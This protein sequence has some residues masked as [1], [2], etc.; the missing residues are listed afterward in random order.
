MATISNRTL[1]FIFNASSFIS[2]LDYIYEFLYKRI[3]IMLY[4]LQLYKYRHVNI[5]AFYRAYIIDSLHVL[6]YKIINIK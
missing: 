4:I 6:I 3:V 2:C 5:Y 1:N